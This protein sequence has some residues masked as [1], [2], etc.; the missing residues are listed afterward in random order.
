MS[1]PVRRLRAEFASAL[2]LDLLGAAGTLLLASRTWQ[3]VITPRP[4]PLA[5]DVLQL[6]GRTIDD[7][8]TAL[9]LVALAGV[10]AVLATRGLGRRVIGAVLALAGAALVWRALL[11][12][13]A[14][15]AARARSLVRSK[16]TGVA[17]DSAVAPHVTVHPQWAIVTVLC[18]VVIVTAGVL[19]ALRGPTWAAMSARY[20]APGTEAPLSEVDAENLRTRASASLW[21][22]LDRGDDPTR[23]EAS[24]P[25][26]PTN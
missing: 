26:E 19:I 25:A 2:L 18:G 17:I 10:V 6:T 8:G 13:D 15:S 3:T 12:L 11:G 4:R 21:T 7:A 20:E 23:S 5:D 16:H 9:S 24:D 1:N 14:V 22:A